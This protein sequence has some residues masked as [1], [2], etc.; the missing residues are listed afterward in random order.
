MELNDITNL[1][2][3]PG[4][5]RTTRIQLRLP[6]E[7]APTV[8][9]NQDNVQSNHQRRAVG[10]TNIDLWVDGSLYPNDLAARYH[11]TFNNLSSFLQYVG[12]G[13]QGLLGY[14][15]RLSIADVSKVLWFSHQ[16]QSLQHNVNHLQHTLMES[17]KVSEQLRKD[18]EQRQEEISKLE[19]KVLH[20]KQTPLGSRE[21][22]RCFSAIET[23]APQGGARKRRV[24]ATKNFIQEACG[25]ESLHDRVNLLTSC[26]TKADIISILRAPKGNRINAAATSEVMHRLANIVSDTDVQK[27]CDDV[28]IS[29]KGY[30]AIH[31]LL[32]DA[33]RE[34]GITENLFPLPHRVNLAK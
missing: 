17:E 16:C 10:H 23:L 28:G 34:R 3:A 18:L 4:S 14:C 22:K 15:K 31:Q 9:T 6:K 24:T 19:S 25:S 5:P 1:P 11:P 32:K 26:I 2:S 27:T 21:H 20:L 13:E 30:V 8:R 33:L 12:R 7:F 29:Q